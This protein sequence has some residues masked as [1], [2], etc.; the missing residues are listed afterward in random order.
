[1]RKV[2]QRLI[3]PGVIGSYHDLHVAEE[4]LGFLQRSLKFGQ[5]VAQ[6]DREYHSL[7]I[8]VLDSAIRVVHHGPELRCNL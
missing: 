2:F 7:S 3:D 5:I 1:M 4:P 6:A 8:D